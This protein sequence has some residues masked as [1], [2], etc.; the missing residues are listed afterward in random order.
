VVTT[1]TAAPAREDVH[2]E[3][4][5]PPAPLPED[6]AVRLTRGQ[7]FG[8]ALGSLVLVYG[9]GLVVLLAGGTVIHALDPARRVDIFAAFHTEWVVGILL[10]IA[11]LWLVPP[12]PWAKRVV[13]P[14]SQE[15]PAQAGRTEDGGGGAFTVQVH[16]P[17]PDAVHR[18]SD[19]RLGSLGL[20]EGGSRRARRLQ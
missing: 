17:G 2:E 3:R 15:Q 5:A 14:A 10:G 20:S 1:E 18:P 16:Q 12:H 13:A 19:A 8:L 7:S 11:V 4:S 9:L 6:P